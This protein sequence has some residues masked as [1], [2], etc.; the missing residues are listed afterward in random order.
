MIKTATTATSMNLLKDFSHTD[1]K[2]ILWQ[3]FVEV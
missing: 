3:E 1:F 2:L